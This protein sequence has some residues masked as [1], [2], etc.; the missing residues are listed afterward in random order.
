M[1]ARR[2]KG[3]RRISPRTRATS[4]TSRSLRCESSLR[5]RFTSLL[6]RFCVS[7]FAFRVSRLVPPNYFCYRKT[8]SIKCVHVCCRKRARSPEGPMRRREKRRRDPTSVP[9]LVSPF[10][11][12]PP[13]P[14]YLFGS[15][16]HHFLHLGSLYFTRVRCFLRFRVKT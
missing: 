7:R 8:P 11:L 14:G 10:D 9:F 5:R 13:E 4:L 12:S 1:R 6:L 16:F 2:R 3:P 15:N